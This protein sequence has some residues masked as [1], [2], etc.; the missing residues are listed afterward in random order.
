MIRRTLALV[1]VAALSIPLVLSARS[2]GGVTPILGNTIQHELLVVY[3]VTGSTLAGPLN[4][5]LEVYNDGTAKIS[6]DA[7][8]SA[9]A[10]DARVVN[11]GQLAALAFAKDLRAAGAWTLSDQQF[12]VSDVPLKTLTVLRGFNGD[13]QGRAF[14]YWVGINEYQG[15][16]LAV[17]LFISQH[18]P[19]F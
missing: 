15:V 16:E 7:G 8:Q 13:L 9:D 12:A 3:D 11:V 19:G 1:L 2:Q 14:N 10:G 6:G 17:Q 5:N 4:L 18:F